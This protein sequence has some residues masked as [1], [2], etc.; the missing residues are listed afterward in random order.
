[1]MKNS[2]RWPFGERAEGVTK[3]AQLMERT[4]R[5]CGARDPPLLHISAA[6]LLLEV[7]LSIP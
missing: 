4:S 7:S 1:M 3:I 6:T 2:I 5:I